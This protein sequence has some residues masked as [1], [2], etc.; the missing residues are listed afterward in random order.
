MTARAHN[1]S[2]LKY[3]RVN[4]DRVPLNRPRFPYKYHESARVSFLDA[5][6]DLDYVSKKEFV[7]QQQAPD[8]IDVPLPDRLLTI[9]QLNH[10]FQ[11]RP[12]FIGWNGK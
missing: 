7:Q 4:T 3:T 6:R 11:K 5:I 12:I 1:N 10:L 9:S 8:P 2:M